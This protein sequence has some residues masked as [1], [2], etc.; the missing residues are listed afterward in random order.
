MRQTGWLESAAVAASLLPRTPGNGIQGLDIR[1]SK[2]RGVAGSGIAKDLRPRRFRP[3]GHQL[4]QIAFVRSIVRKIYQKHNTI[5]I[6]VGCGGRGGIRTH[7]TLS[8]TPVF[9]TGALNHSATLP[10]SEVSDLAGVCGWGKHQFGQARLRGRLEC[11]KGS[12]A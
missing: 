6:S 11:L 4:G 1:R 7:G 8:R 2:R 9:K 12:R 3:G 10:S 5:T